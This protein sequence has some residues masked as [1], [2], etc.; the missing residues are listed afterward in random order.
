VL[1]ICPTSVIGNWQRE[2]QR[3]APG[4]KVTR[5]H[6]AERPDHPDAVEDV[7]VTT[8]G[9]LRRDVD[10]LAARQWSVV[11]LDEAQQVKNPQ[12]AGAKA[13]R[14]LQRRQTVALTGTPLENRLAELWALLDVTNPG[15]LGRRSD[16]ARRFVKPVERHHDRAAAPR[17]RRL[18]AP[19]ILRREKSDPAVI[20]D[21]PPKIERTVT[22]PLTP[23]QAGLYTAAVERVLGSGDLHEGSAIQRRG[24][25]LALLTELKQICNHPAHY[26]REDAPT[27]AGRSGKLAV[28][29]EIITEA[30]AGDEQVLVFTQ[31]VAMGHLLVEQLQ[32]DL[33][34]SIPF[35]H[36]GL[37]A[38][39]RDKIVSQFQAR[40]DGG[41]VFGDPPPVL[42][43]SLRAGGTGLNLTAA[44]HV[45]HYDRW[46][47]P[48]VED[49]ATD[50]AHRIGQLRTVEVHKLVTAGTLE[51]R[52]DELLTS[53]RALAE[54]VV[55]AGES[56]LTELGDAELRELIALSRDADI[57][58]LD[59]DPA[60]D[61]VATG[62][63]A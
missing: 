20:A 24:R 7:V 26:L 38:T 47:N 32:A 9:T 63:L 11:A 41:D 60:D 39:A 27:L 3:F 5:W 36:G 55:G 56:W 46:W 15:L 4:L 57:T 48:A 61:L 2:F 49:Q 23:E 44:T 19:F 10:A 31:Y 21:L 50:R 22:C 30:V 51:E 34:V 18:V 33:G 54:Q 59:E 28:A 8:Y 25:V 1:V 42:V 14:R 37:P 58:E 52:I 16:F 40:I 29:R 17:L 45:L 53:K 62:P 13:V 43:I 12:T 35:L 6:G